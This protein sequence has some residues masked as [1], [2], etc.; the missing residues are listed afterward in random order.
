VPVG[1]W[2]LDQACARGAIWQRHGHGINVAVNI[3][4]KQ[5]TSDRI[6]D[7][8]ARALARSGLDPARLTLEMTET[9]LMFEIEEALP[10]L[11]MLKAFGVRIA[12]DNFGTGYSSLAYLRQF[13]I[14]ILKIDRSFVT[15]M[16]N[17]LEAAALV[18]TLVRL[19][20]VLDLETVAQGIENDAQLSQLQAEEIDTGQGF[21]FSRPIDASSVTRLIG[22][23]PL[24]LDSTRSRHSLAR[25]SPILAR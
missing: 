16:T 22:G 4:A 5:L 21:L 7:D 8:V 14:D 2:V 24:A 3:S 18:H 19:G 17:S 20:K 11:A 15:D 12:I 9:A 1:A 25:K 13:P 6:V 10:R 23:A